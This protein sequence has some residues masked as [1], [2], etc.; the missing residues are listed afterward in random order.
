MSAPRNYGKW[1]AEAYMPKMR[2]MSSLLDVQSLNV[3]LNFAELEI[4]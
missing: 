4:Q 2:E 3:M 1:Y